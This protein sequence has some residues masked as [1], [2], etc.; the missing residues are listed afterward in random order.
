MQPNICPKYTSFIWNVVL[1]IW[2]QFNI[3]AGEF[4]DQKMKD[5]W[6]KFKKSVDF[7]EKLA[8]LSPLPIFVW[9]FVELCPLG[10]DLES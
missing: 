3:P 9:L 8:Y 2:N 10:Y 4:Q 6:V 7:S 1:L 5:S